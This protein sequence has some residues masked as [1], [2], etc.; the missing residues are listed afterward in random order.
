MEI[1]GKVGVKVNCILNWNTDYARM[2][3]MQ[4]LD[5]QTSFPIIIADNEAVSL[6]KELEKVEIKR[7][8]T[9]DLFFDAL[10][11]FHIRIREVYIHKLAEGIFYTKLFCEKDDEWVEIDARP[12]DAII[13]AIK[14]NAPI[15]VEELILEKLGILTTDMEKHIFPDSESKKEGS[16]AEEPLEQ[17]SAQDLEEKLRQSIEIEDFEM[18]SK[19]RDIIKERKNNPL[20]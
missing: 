14:G 17:Q 2:L 19:I 4:T 16:E 20:Q 3:V 10:Q 7:P 11:S 15:F 13:L 6:L 1:M 9:H 18:A 12:S 5:G 8:L